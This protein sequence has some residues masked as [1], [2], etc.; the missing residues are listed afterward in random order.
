[1]S[2]EFRMSTDLMSAPWADQHIGRSWRDTRLEDDC[3]C[4]QEPCGLVNVNRVD[5]DCTEHPIE[6]AKSI[7]QSHTATRCPGARE[8]R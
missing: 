5:P 6:R 2:A 3:P 4:P 7:R 1:M 8:P